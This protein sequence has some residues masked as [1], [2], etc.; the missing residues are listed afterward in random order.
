MLK[1]E[2]G[3]QCGGETQ[4]MKKGVR[5]TKNKYNQFIVRNA[6]WCVCKRF[7]IVFENW[8]MNQER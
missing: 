2:L 7:N 3:R 6:A 4:G 8:V 1:G 5:T